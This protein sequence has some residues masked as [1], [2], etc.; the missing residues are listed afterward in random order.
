M[1]LQVRHTIK[2][3]LRMQETILGQ[4]SLAVPALSM[5]NLILGSF[6]GQLCLLENN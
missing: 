4:P 5:L 2:G 1:L 6:L 3:N